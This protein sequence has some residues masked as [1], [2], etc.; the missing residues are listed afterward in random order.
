VRLEIGGL[1]LLVIIGALIGGLGL[2]RILVR[3]EAKTAICP[4]SPD[5]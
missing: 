3:Y 4:Q 1:I 5:H 2:E